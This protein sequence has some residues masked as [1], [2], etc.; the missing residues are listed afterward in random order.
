M[1]QCCSSNRGPKDETPPRLIHSQSIPDSLHITNYKNQSITLQFDE[2][3]QLK[4][5]NSEL[6]ITPFTDPTSIK[7][8]VKKNQLILTF[9]EPLDSNTTYIINLGKSI[10]DTKEGKVSNNLTFCFSTG[11]IID[12]LTI[13][14]T[15]R[16]HLSTKPM[17]QLNVGL[18]HEIWSDTLTNSQPTYSTTTDSKGNFEFNYLKNQA[19]QIIAYRDN[20]QNQQFDPTSESV[21]FTDHI[22]QPVSEAT[23]DLKLISP[24]TTFEITTA[25]PNQ[26]HYVINFSKGLKSIH[27]QKGQTQFLTNN[28]K[29]LKVWP[30]VRPTS[31]SILFIVQG[32]DTL[33]NSLDTVLKIPRNDIESP[34]LSKDKISIQHTDYQF[35]NKYFSTNIHFSTLLE[36]VILDSID[37]YTAIDTANLKSIQGFTT[38]YDTTLSILTI[39][40]DN[41]KSPI[42]IKFKSKSLTRQTIYNEI[43]TKTFEQASLK[44]T[45]T[46]SG[47][48]VTEK[49]NLIFELVD[50]K[51][52]VIETLYNPKEFEFKY[53][54]PDSYHIIIT[55]DLNDNKIYDTGKYSTRTLPE[56]RYHDTQVIKLKANWEITDVNITYP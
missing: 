30:H 27:S 21:A 37:I 13:S 22:I 29:Q 46:I 31:D 53:L 35:I 28:R 25:R 55:E 42:T 45:G 16:H 23:I 26:D 32:T 4:N 19:Y 41:I 8:I 12:S 10:A 3:I 40:S 18:Y 56:P 54:K 51:L 5:I 15:I 39:S 7:S 33:G 11:P 49:K 34:D 52:N 50:S 36:S 43:I 20:N 17:A 38:I 47:T 2:N 48:F 1:C 24:T 9:K 44:T 6:K 14:G